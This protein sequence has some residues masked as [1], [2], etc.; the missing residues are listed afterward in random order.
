MYSI[1]TT[2]TPNYHKQF[3]SAMSVRSF[4]LHTTSKL[5]PL[6]KEYMCFKIDGKYYQAYKCVESRIM[7]KLIDCVIY[8]N[9]FEQQCVLIKGML[10]SPRLKYHME[11]IGIEQ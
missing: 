10:Q 11:T 8:I 6:G 7:T 1:P 4:N 9:T 2:L 3:I 5:T